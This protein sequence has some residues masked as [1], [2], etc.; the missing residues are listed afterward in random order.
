MSNHTDTADSPS[1]VVDLELKI[2]L[3][4]IAHISG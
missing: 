3:Q 2:V 1:I 4:W